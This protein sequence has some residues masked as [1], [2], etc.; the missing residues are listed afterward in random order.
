MNFVAGEIFSRDLYLTIGL[1]F[2]SKIRSGLRRG[3]KRRGKREKREKERKKIVVITLALNHCHE[4]QTRNNF[5][6]C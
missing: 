3:G 4:K 5:C 6:D 1:T 2:V